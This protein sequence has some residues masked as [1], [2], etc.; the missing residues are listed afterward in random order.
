MILLLTVRKDEFEDTKGYLSNM[1]SRYIPKWCHCNEIKL[2]P[3]LAELLSFPGGDLRCQPFRSTRVHPQFLVGFV[4][5]DIYIRH[6]SGD[7]CI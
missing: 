6:C 5:L 2:Q 1:M 4:L 7:V 3:L